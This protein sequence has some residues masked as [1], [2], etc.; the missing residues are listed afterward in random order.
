[1][2]LGELKKASKVID[3]PAG[4]KKEMVDALVKHF[5]PERKRKRADTAPPVVPAETGEEQE[6]GRSGEEED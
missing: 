4:S 3:L 6:G 5:A 1:M 2:S